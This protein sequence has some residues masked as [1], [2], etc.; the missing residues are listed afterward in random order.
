MA[1]GIARGVV[2]VDI[3]PDMEQAG[4]NRIQQF[5]AEHALTG[6]A[7]LDEVAD[8]VAAYNP[9]RPRPTDLSGLRK[10]VRERDGRWYWHWDPAFVG[11]TADLPP[12]E[13]GDTDRADGRRGHHRGGHAPAAGAGPGQRPRHRG[14]GRR[15][16]APRSPPPSTSTC[17]A[18]AT[19]SPAIATTP[20]PP[21]SSTSSTATAE[22]RSGSSG[23]KGRVRDDRQR[24]RSWR[25]ALVGVAIVAVLGASCASSS[26]ESRVRRRAVDDAGWVA[27]E[28][29]EVPE[30]FLVCS[31]DQYSSVGR[32]VAYGPVAEG[33][34]DN[35]EVTITA[36]TSFYGYSIDEAIDLAER[37]SV[38]PV[39]VAEVDGHR[40]LVG[41]MTDEGRVYGQR[42]GWEQAPGLVIMVE[43]SRYVDSS[44]WPP[45][46]RP[47]TWPGRW[48][49]WTGPAGTGP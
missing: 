41:P 48:S 4:A 24:R 28:L 31:V 36:S 46:S 25:R 49:A 15:R 8:A 9:H 19:W 39:T 32:R 26:T 14:E 42:V 5:M 35:C 45:R 13:I 37:N 47:S 10:N 17:P 27:A 43:D 23:G 22:P 16:S 12:S 38:E 44:R 11:G 21:P 33:V 6:F 30:G 3:V 18:P 29:S 1:P 34:G 20:S 40:A 7:S 2:L